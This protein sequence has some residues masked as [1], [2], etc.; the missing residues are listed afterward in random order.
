MIECGF[1]GP[2]SIE[3]VHTPYM[4]ASSIDVITETIKMRELVRT[5]AAARPV[6]L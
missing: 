1:L 2:V 6:G 3:Y 5:W 4:G